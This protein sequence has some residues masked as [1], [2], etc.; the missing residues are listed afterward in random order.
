MADPKER[1]STTVVVDGESGAAPVSALELERVRGKKIVC[2][3]SNLDK[4]SCA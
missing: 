1:S 4:L 2:G 3:Y